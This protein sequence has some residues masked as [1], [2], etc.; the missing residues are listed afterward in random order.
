MRNKRVST[1]IKNILRAFIAKFPD[2]SLTFLHSKI[3][4]DFSQNS[5]T[6]PWP[7]KMKFFPDFSLTAGNPVMA[8]CLTAP[9]H[10]LN[11]CW[12]IITDVLWHSPKSNFT[13]SNIN[14]IRNM[15]S[16]TTY[17]KSLPPVLRGSAECSY[18]QTSNTR[19]T[20]VGNKIVD[21]SDVAGASPVGAA[22]TTS[23]FST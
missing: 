8:W 17:S 15:C 19:C 1:S 11:Q 20:F 18:Y 5:L 10:Y 16:E 3:F 6:F 9:S 7:W 12:L 4:P 2:Y 22:P 21:H 13:R 14:L 23:S